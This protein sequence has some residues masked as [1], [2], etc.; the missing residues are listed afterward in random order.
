MG[1]IEKIKG[2]VSIENPY[3]EKLDIDVTNETETED[4]ALPAAATAVAPKPATGIYGQDD[5]VVELKVVRPTTFANVTE[6]ADY[7]MHNCTVVLNLEATNTEEAKR[8]LDFLAGV[9]YSIDGQLKNIAVNT[10]IIT[11]CNVDVADTQVRAAEAQQDFDN[12][13]ANANLT[14]DTLF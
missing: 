8:L 3:D 6:I 11:P 9:A 10:Y 5:S 14:S 4:I 13:T 7:L 12:Q 2:M 1:L